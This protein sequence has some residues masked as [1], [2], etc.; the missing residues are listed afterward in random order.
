MA[1]SRICLPN[2]FLNN[3]VTYILL[4]VALFLEWTEQAWVLARVTKSMMKLQYDEVYVGTP[5]ERVANNHGDQEKMLG[6]CELT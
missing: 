1:I 3:P 6:A 4:I 2:A 5:E